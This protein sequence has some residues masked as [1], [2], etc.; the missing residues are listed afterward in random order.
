MNNK[1]LSL[2]LS[3]LLIFLFSCKNQEPK[4][5]PVDTDQEIVYVKKTFLKPFSGYDIAG[6]TIRLSTS[7]N[8]ILPAGWVEVTL[9]A[10]SPHGHFFLVFVR[11]V[12]DQQMDYTFNLNDLDHL[13]MND[14][15]YSKG[16]DS[17]ELLYRMLM[18]SVEPTSQYLTVFYSLPAICEKVLPNPKLKRGF[19]RHFSQEFG[20]EN[21]VLIQPYIRLN[22]LLLA[23]LRKKGLISGNDRAYCNDGFGTAYRYKKVN[24]LE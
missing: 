21:R 19:Q 5:L 22:T 16:K 12:A 23:D 2:Y 6:E 9:E 1:R 11:D 17:T 3:F 7:G 10:N 18:K 15:I 8:K 24:E 4:K 13:G 20:G 14:R